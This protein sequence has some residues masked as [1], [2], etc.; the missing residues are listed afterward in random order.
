LA[1]GTA[2]KTAARGVRLADEEKGMKTLVR[3][4]CLVSIL[5]I[6]AFGQRG[7]FG[8]RGGF[9]HGFRGGFGHGF[10]GGGFGHGFRG[11]FGGFGHFR[12]GFRGFVAPRTF[13][14]NKS[15]FFSPRFHGSF[16]FNKPFFTPFGGFR[17]GFRRFGGFWGVPV[18]PYPAYGGYYGGYDGAYPYAGPNVTV[19][20]P[21]AAPT[22]Y[23]EP[24]QQQQEE[25]SS[26]SVVIN[27]YRWGSSSNVA[28]P[29]K[30]VYFSIAMRDGSVIDAAAYWVD[31]G[32]LN[33]VDRQGN[34]GE[35]PVSQV[36]ESR[37]QVLNRERGIEFGLPKSG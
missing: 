16:F 5:S 12:P 20:Y 25:T 14:F 3:L 26:P 17:F 9:G 8:M 32:T 19:I 33:Y 30:M 24:A 21:S 31:N 4:L 27:E 23:Y 22:D 10:R 2:L 15:P 1:A 28:T 35:V 13:F 34:R 11:G 29:Q 36:D 6:S 37:S 7:G 18:W